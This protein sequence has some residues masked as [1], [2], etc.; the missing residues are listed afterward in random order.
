MSFPIEFAKSRGDND[1][2]SPY[3]NFM[4]NAGVVAVGGIS[5]AAILGVALKALGFC[6]AAATIATA[7]PVTFGVF[8]VVANLAGTAYL[9]RCYAVRKRVFT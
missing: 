6:S 4:G 5:L 9:Y 3:I 1:F 2:I 7:I 8:C